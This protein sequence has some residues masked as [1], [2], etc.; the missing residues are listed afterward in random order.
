MPMVSGLVYT[1]VEGN[2]DQRVEGHR[3]KR[4]L[5]RG[6][7]K[8]SRIPGASSGGRISYGNKPGRTLLHSIK[9]MEK[10]LNDQE[11]DIVKL[12]AR[13][14]EQDTDITTLQQNDSKKELQNLALRKRVDDHERKG[15]DQ[16]HEIMKLLPVQDL[17]I[18]IRKR[19][20]ATNCRSNDEK[21][22]WDTEVIYSGN[23][24]AHAGDV[25]LD[26]HLFQT[27]SLIKDCDTFE[28]LYGVTWQ[29][30]GALIEYPQLVLA[31][32][33]RATELAKKH[34]KWAKIHEDAYRNLVIYVVNATPEDLEI[35]KTDDLEKDTYHRRLFESL[36]NKL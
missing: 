3:V 18:G 27:G 11:T 24:R 1:E 25:C 15:R 23:L 6:I 8:I 19:F 7:E 10:R 21:L 13:A 33:T 26:F 17:A 31:M 12:L 14:A 22:P 2:A 30:A 4:S 28:D 20:F 29:A 35:F 34:S 36:N 16:A 5:I 9:L 32:N